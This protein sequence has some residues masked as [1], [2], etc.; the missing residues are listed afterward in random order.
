MLVFEIGITSS[1][2]HHTNNRERDFPNFRCWSKYR[3][4]DGCS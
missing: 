3:A 4:N 2:T 1:L